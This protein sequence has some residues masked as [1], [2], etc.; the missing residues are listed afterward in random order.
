[1]VGG[2]MCPSIVEPR[3]GSSAPS[4]LVLGSSSIRETF[5]LRALLVRR[6][7]EPWENHRLH[8]GI[9]ALERLGSVSSKSLE[10]AAGPKILNLYNQELNSFLGS[11]GHLGTT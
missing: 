9:E 7:A 3:P 4:S 2:K 11:K 1:M 10:L 8:E 5:G 6:R